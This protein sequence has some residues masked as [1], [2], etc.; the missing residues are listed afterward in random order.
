LL[1][2]G[3]ILICTSNRSGK[4]ETYESGTQVKI[5]TRNLD[6]QLVEYHIHYMA[7]T[8]DKK[9]TE[10]ISLQNFYFKK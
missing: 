2:D 3:R 9:N 10:V 8:A 4:P 5:Y 6:P 1:D 7:R